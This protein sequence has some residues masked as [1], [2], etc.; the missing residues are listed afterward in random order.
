MERNAYGYYYNPNSRWD[1]YQLGGR[2][3]DMFLVKDTCTEYFDGE[4]S[5][6]IRES[7]LETPEGFRW[8]AAARKKDIEWQAMRNWKNQKV[9]ERFYSLEKM[10]CAGELAEDFYGTLTDE[11]IMKQG[12]LVYRKGESVEA[13]LQRM[14]IPKSRKYPFAVGDIVDESHWF[15]MEDFSWNMEAAGESETKKWWTF[16]DEYV[17]GITDEMVLVGVDYHM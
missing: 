7:K 10:F 3:P 1:W 12:E 9:T 15:G 11:G 13:Y 6:Y 2:W 8:V 4:Y 5:C 14:S 16:L 17:D